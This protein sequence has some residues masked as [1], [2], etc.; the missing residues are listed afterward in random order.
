MYSEKLY[1]FFLTCLLR[2]QIERDLILPFIFIFT[3]I[4]S[5]TN[6]AASALVMILNLEWFSYLV[7]KLFF[8]L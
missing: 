4:R 1:I 5:S 8:L 2:D 7:K 3:E 6:F